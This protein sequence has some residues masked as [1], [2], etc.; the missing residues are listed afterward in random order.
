MEDALDS[1]R[2]ALRWG[3]AFALTRDGVGGGT[4]PRGARI[5]EIAVEALGH[6]D[7]DLRWAAVAIIRGLF[8]V[9]PRLGQLLATTASKDENAQR[10]KMSLYC[11]R[12]IGEK[13]VGVFV[14]GLGHKDTGVRLAALSG[15]AATATTEATALAGIKA[16]ECNDSEPGVRRAA[17]AVLAR[18]RGDS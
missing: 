6:P 14:A 17:A 13:D 5:V 18:L 2:S 11:L 16:C 12:D 1:S 10:V 8:P 15:L 4:S 9:Q 7:G 3:A